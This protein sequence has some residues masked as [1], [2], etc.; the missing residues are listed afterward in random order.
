L[1]GSQIGFQIT[2]EDVLPSTDCA[3]FADKVVSDGLEATLSD[4]PYPNGG[5]AKVNVDISP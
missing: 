4:V 5:S 3:T 2:A 1:N